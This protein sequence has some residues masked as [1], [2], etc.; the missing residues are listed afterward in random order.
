LAAF[1]IVWSTPAARQCRVFA[2]SR[3]WI[4]L[5]SLRGAQLPGR[6]FSR[7]DGLRYAWHRH[8][9]RY[10]SWSFQP[11]PLPDIARPGM[12][13]RAIRNRQELVCESEMMHHCA[14]RTQSYTRRVIARELYFYRMI[15]PERLTIAVRP[16]RNV[17]LLKRFEEFITS[18][19]ET[20]PCG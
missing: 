8:T 9:S 13:I 10:D 3:I 18:S 16:D 7:I 20:L 6:P 1:A 17:G 2:K 19:Q 14:G 11:P 15:E 5:L 12:Q 4:G